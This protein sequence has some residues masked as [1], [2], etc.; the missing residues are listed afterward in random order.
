[1]PARSLSIAE[2][3]SGDLESAAAWY[4][5]RAAVLATRFVDA[6][7]QAVL[8]VREFPRGGPTA[9]GWHADCSASRLPVSIDYEVEQDAV[10]I[11]AVGHM[12]R[13]DFWS[14]RM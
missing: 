7:E 10:R 1:V 5:D 3:V 4:A 11:I 9:R 14:E 12:S 13:D 8:H 6:F 2:E